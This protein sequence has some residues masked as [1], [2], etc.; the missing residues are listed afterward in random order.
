MK[1]MREWR[2]SL[3]RTLLTSGMK[4]TVR[5]VY[6]KEKQERQIEMAAP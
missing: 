4:R 6:R 1:K 3:Y 2:A 5:N